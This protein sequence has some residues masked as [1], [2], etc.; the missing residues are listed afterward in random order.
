MTDNGQASRT[1]KLNG[2]K[3]NLHT[4]GFKT[5]KGSPYEGGTHVPAFWH[6]KGVLGESVDINALTAHIDLYQTF[7]ELAGVQIP[8]SVQ[9][10]DGRSL[11]PL[12]ESPDAEWADR[13]LFVHKGRWEKGADPNGSQFKN[14]AVRT[15]RWRFVNNKELYDISVDPYETTDVAQDHPEVIAKL[16]KTYEQ[17]WSDTVPLMVNEDAPYAPEHPQAVRY[18]KQLKEKGIPDWEP[19]KI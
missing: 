4:A 2:K 17:W 7:C 10:I 15:K 16:R 8:D 9:S 11:V 14:C 18:N 12:L 19:P 3:V 5:G 13:A 1:G 6:W